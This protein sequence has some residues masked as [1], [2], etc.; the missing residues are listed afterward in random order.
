M[1]ALTFEFGGHLTGFAPLQVSELEAAVRLPTTLCALTW[2]VD[3][4]CAWLAGL[5]VYR[6]PPID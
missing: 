3:R 4:R 5:A 6:Q 1:G 2:A